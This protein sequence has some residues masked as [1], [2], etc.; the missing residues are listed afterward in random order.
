MELGGPGVGIGMLSWFKMGS[1][2]YIAQEHVEG[3]IR[4]ASFTR[5]LV[6]TFKYGAVF[7]KIMITTLLWYYKPVFESATYT[8]PSSASHAH[9]H[10]A[11][12][13]LA[14]SRQLI[15]L[16]PSVGGAVLDSKKEESSGL[17]LIS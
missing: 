14:T 13:T 10:T 7:P 15:R 17:E 8:V 16:R 1:L 5:R 9:R 6:E 12:V 11:A 3:V 4:V 2:V